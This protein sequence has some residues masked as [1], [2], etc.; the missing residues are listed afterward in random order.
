PDG[1][2]ATFFTTTGASITQFNGDRY[3]QYKAYLST[4]DTAV[5]PTVND[6]SVCFGSAVINKAPSGSDGTVIASE[7]AG[8]AFAAAD[9]GFS[10]N[11]IT[12]DVTAVNDA[13]VNTVPGAQSAVPLNTD[14]A[15][16]GVSASDVDAAA[17]SDVVTMSLGVLHG[18]VAVR[19][20]VSGGLVAG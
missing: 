13:P 17:G 10:P 16:A 5:T 12:V 3:L 9:F 2:A 7:D 11:T 14:Y 4:T 1:T 15:I 6:V 18:T 8:Y 19:T 20:D